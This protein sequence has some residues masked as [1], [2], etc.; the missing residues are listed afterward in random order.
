[1]GADSNTTLSGAAGIAASGTAESTAEALGVSVSGGGSAGASVALA[2]A[3]PAISAS[4]GEAANLTAASLL[5]SARQ[6]LP[7]SGTSADAHAT[8]ASAG[9]L[10]GLNAT[11]AEAHGGG[12]VAAGIGDDAIVTTSGATRIEAVGE[13]TQRADASGLSLGIVALG[14][15]ISTADSVATT[16]TASTGD[17]VKLTA[18]STAIHA[19]S[20]SDNLPRP[21]R[22]VAV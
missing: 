14:A 10:V 11:V 13:S 2:T 18:G 20:T 9:L 19:A 21:P 17:K 12:L 1:M 16:T 22:A 6:G 5:V 7:G 3:R 15:N 4:L 8:G